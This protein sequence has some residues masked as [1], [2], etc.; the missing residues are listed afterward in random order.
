MSFNKVVAA[1]A[2]VQC[3]CY[4]CSCDIGPSETDTCRVAIHK[5]HPEAKLA[6]FVRS[7]HNTWYIVKDT[8]YMC[9]DGRAVRVGEVLP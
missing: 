6:R 2:M 4:G 1:V 7:G 8:A 5:R 9:V 3:L